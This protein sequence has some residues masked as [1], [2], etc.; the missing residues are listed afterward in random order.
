MVQVENLWDFSTDHP[1]FAVEPS[2]HA[3]CAGGWAWYGP[4]VRL[5]PGEEFE[6]DEHQALVDVTRWPESEAEV[7]EYLERQP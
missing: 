1:L 6:L 4:V 3:V 7:R 2:L 5:R